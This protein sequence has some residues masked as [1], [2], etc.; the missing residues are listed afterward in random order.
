MGPMATTL[1]PSIFNDVVGPVMRGPSSSHSAASVRIARMARGPGRRPARQGPGGVRHRGVAGHHPRQPGARTW[2]SSVGCSAGTRTTRGWASPR[3]TWR[4]PGSSWRSRSPASMTPHPNT[5][6]MTLWRGGEAH[7]MV[8]IST[9]GGID[10]GHRDRRRPGEPAGRLRRDAD[11]P[12]RERGARCAE[13]L[14]ERS[15]VD[16]AATAGDA[17]VRGAREG[18]P[19]RRRRRRARGCSAAYVAWPPSSRCAR[20]PAYDRP[21]PPRGRDGGDRRPRHPPPLVL[22]PWSTSAPA[23]A[24]GEA[25]VM[26]PDAAHPPDRPRGNQGGPRGYRVR[27][28]RA[29]APEPPVRGEA[30]RGASSMTAACSIRPSS[31]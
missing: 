14:A 17:M 16:V 11:R 23:A 10:R 13:A 9:G 7:R 26:G 20:G 22:R 29:P 18:G 8:A 6:R 12:R 27:R 21:L 25:E 28:P 30:R 31:T 3:R 4:R 24:L 2:A 19:L 5:Y 15:D 1:P